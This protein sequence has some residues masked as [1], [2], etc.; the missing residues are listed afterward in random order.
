MV[1]LF[2][3]HPLR[4]AVEIAT[5]F[6]LP[7]HTNGQPVSLYDLAGSVVLLEFFWTECSHCRAATPQ[8]KTNI[9][10]YYQT[11]GGNADGLPVAVFYISV[12]S[13][14]NRVDDFIRD[15]GLDLVADDLQLTVFRQFDG[16]YVPRFIAI[17][18]VTNSTTHLPWQM[19]YS[20]EGYGASTVTSLRT[21]ID[22]VQRTLAP[23][24]SNV[25]ML[26]NTTFK[27][28][29]QAQ[30]GRTNKVQASTNLVTWVTLTNIVDS[31]TVRFVDP[32]ARF[33]DRRFYRVKVSP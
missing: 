25:K 5:N 18:G 29:F 12:S 23:R 22:A 2:G 32:E 33:F 1:L 13:A 21:H 28:S 4:G 24:I 11:R 16:Y 27:A 17:N 15:Y 10:D 3:A 30:S 26:T 19:L 31:N 20:E 6:T 9:H 14:S 7:Q 8:L